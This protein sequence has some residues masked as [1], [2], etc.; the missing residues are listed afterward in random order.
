MSFKRWCMQKYSTKNAEE[1]TH[2]FMDKG[3]IKVP[4][5][6]YK[7]FLKKYYEFKDV[8]DISLVEKLGKNILMRFFLDIDMKNVKNKEEKMCEI[9]N[10]SNEIL[11]DAPIISEC[12]EKQGYH[13][14]YNKICTCEECE[15]YASKIKK[16]S[17]N[18]KYID[19]SVYKSGLRM[20]GSVKNQEKRKYTIKDENFQTFKHTVVRICK[21]EN[22]VKP[23][24]EN[25]EMNNSNQELKKIQSVI[26]LIWNIDLN[27][28][29]VKKIGNY[30]SYITDSKY[31]M[32]I[33]KE[34]KNA[35]VYYVYNTH[36]KEIYQKC[37]CKCDKDVGPFVKCMNYKSKSEKV[38]YL[39]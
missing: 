9:V 19:T 39:F 21:R 12:S 20:V 38:P 11:N 13:I 2:L 35:K 4:M 25:T 8:E 10:I 15:I 18:G 27:V 29:S 28:I 6:D 31:C 3:K 14:I 36:S 32:N 7:D 33:K 17:T 24:S 23:K 37:F 34:H 26:K 30:E 22:N 5:C 16:E 1:A